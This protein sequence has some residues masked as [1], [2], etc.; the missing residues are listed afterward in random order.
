MIDDRGL[1]IELEVD[2]GVHLDNVAEVANAGAD[3]VVMG[4]GVFGTPAPDKTIGRVRELCA[5]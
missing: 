3:V 4:A 5:R 2:G 1:D